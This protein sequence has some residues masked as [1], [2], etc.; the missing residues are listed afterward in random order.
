MR[1]VLDPRVAWGEKIL[2]VLA[3]AYVLLP[4][5]LVPDLIPVVGWLDDAGILAVGILL[6]L[7]AFGRYRRRVGAARP[8]TG[9]AAGSPNAGSRGLVESVGVDVTPK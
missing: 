2:G 6:L 7:R 8:P 5:D 1:F 3:L 9:T 4:I